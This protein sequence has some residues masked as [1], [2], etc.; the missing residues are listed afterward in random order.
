MQQS[1]IKTEILT[2]GMSLSTD[3]APV[4]SL[5][6]MQPSESL[7]RVFADVCAQRPPAYWDYAKY[8]LHWR[9]QSDY[10]IMRKIGQGKYSEVFEG[11]QMSKNEPCVIKILKPVRRKKIKREIS[12]LKNLKGGTNIIRVLDTVRD[13]QSKTPSLIFEHVN[14]YEYRKLYPK[15]TDYDMRYYIYE[16]LKALQY[17]HS[18]G[19]MHRDVKPH[20][21][22]IDHSQRKLRLIDWGL[23]EY[24][25]AGQSHIRIVTYPHTQSLC[26]P[27]K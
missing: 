18:H 24:Y 25:L 14:N 1:G 12:I 17:A 15:L 21:V 9:S 20:N 27:D 7:P 10:Q 26:P 23:A 11:V 19:I 5:S 2:V 16:L 4:A 3:T 8:K 22:M 6:T 13:P